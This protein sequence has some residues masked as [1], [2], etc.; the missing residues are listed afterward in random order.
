MTLAPAVWR[1]EV[2]FEYDWQST[3]HLAD[4]PDIWISQWHDNKGAIKATPVLSSPTPLG[5][6]I[7]TRDGKL[8]V[9]SQLLED[10]DNDFCHP[11]RNTCN[12]SYTWDFRY[13]QTNFGC[14]A[15]TD[16]CIISSPLKRLLL[17]IQSVSLSVPHFG[18]PSIYPSVSHSVSWPVIRHI[19]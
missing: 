17:L 14:S 5:P 19:G 2:I 7:T 13:E 16:W 8:N 9:V 10:S 6:H 11:N 18:N 12:H 4:F 1:T 15:R 3:R